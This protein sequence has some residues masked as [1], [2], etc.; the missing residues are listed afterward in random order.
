MTTKEK[1]QEY[2]KNNQIVNADKLRSIVSE[3]CN[4]GVFAEVICLCG[5]FVVWTDGNVHNARIVHECP[6]CKGE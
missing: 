2:V 6:K 1:I 5:E 4:N 3:D